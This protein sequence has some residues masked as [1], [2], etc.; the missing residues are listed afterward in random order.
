LERR[1]CCG[2]EVVFSGDFFLL[3]ERDERFLADFTGAAARAERVLD[4]RA[5]SL[6][7]VRVY[8]ELWKM[9]VL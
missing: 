4:V 7:L 6:L 9:S 3:V 2:W 5:I 8:N 1:G